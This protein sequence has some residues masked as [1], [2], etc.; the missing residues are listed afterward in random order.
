[1]VEEGAGVPDAVGERGDPAPVWPPV[2][3]AT[4]APFPEPAPEVKVTALAPV[5]PQERPVSARGVAKALASREAAITA[6]LR[7]FVAM[8][9]S[10]CDIRDRRLYRETF[11]T[12]EG[13]CRARWGWSQ[14]QADRLIDAATAFHERPHPDDDLTLMVLRRV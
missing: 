6:G 7:S 9:E 8:G 3:A 4:P 1:M 14:S 10:L 5:A 2:E 13:Y 12:F 11:A